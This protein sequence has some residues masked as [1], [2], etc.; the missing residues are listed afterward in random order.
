MGLRASDRARLGKIIMPNRKSPTCRSGFGQREKDEDDE[1][2]SHPGPISVGCLKILSCSVDRQT[3]K[4]AGAR[5]DRQASKSL[6]AILI[7]DRRRSDQS[8]R[9]APGAI[10]MSLA[11]FNGGCR[12]PRRLASRRSMGTLSTSLL[13]CGAIHRGKTCLIHLT[14]E[15]LPPS[16]F[17]REQSVAASSLD[18]PTTWSR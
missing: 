12:P 7:F 1:E 13:S 14:M 3:R 9:H 6:R 11:T 5:Q 15:Q 18:R 4:R 10:A 17:T 16:P 8:S 2:R